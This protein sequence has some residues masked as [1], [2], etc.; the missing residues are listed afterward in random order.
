MGQ[1]VQKIFFRFLHELS[2]SERAKYSNKRA[3]KAKEGMSKLRSTPEGK[4]K[5]NTDEKKRNAKLR[6]T[7][8][9]KEDNRAA[10]EKLRSTPKGRAKHNDDERKRNAEIRTDPEVRAKHNDD[11]RE[12]N[13]EIRSTDEGREA[14]RLATETLRSTDEGREANRE[15]SELRREAKKA[16]LIEK[17][18]NLPFPPDI[19]DKMEKRCIENRMWYMWRSCK[20]KR[21]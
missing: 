1:K 18:A 13:A 4:E 9:G 12:R 21:A 14:N 8:K 16:E 6:S 7:P 5:H 15:A 19:N 2:H 10:S 17:M 20:T 11:E 3:E